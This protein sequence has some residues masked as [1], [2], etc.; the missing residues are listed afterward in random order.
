VEG[1][2]IVL[3]RHGESRAQELG[4]LGGHEGCKGL[5]D[6]GRQQVTALRDRLADTGELA[7][8]SALYASVMPR[9]IETAELIAPALGGLEVRPECDFCEGHPGEADGLSWAEL[10]ERY[11]APAGWDGSTRRAPGWE[12]WKELGDRVA[13][14][15]E[16]L[17]D[18]H[19]GETVVVACHGGVIVHS[20]LHYLG[21]D[22]GGGG[23][24]AWIAPDNSSL[25][26]WRFARNP[27]EKSTL[28]IQLV[29]YN[30]HAHL[31]AVERRPHSI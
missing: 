28:P 8:A 11:P 29:R 3:V 6:L 2:R 22:L 31:S 26:E 25:T 20:V 23:T 30:D 16:G 7:G 18:R 4:I 13:R 5:S 9:A 15:L 24:R 17:V 10:D 14:A 1:T 27:Y 21:L 12:T 19:P